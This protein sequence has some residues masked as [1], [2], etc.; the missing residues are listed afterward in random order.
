MIIDRLSVEYIF[1]HIERFCTIFFKETCW[2]RSWLFVLAAFVP[3]RLCDSQRHGY[4]TWE[5]QEAFGATG[6]A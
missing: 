2:S 6:T 5:N 1:E 3:V 4:L